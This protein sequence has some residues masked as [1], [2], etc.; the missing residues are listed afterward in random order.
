VPLDDGRRLD[1]Y[2]R[3]Q[4]AGPY[5]V[6]PDPEQAVDRKQSRSTGPLATKNAQLMME[7][8]VL[9]FQN[10]PATESARNNGDDGTQVLEHTS[11]TTTVLPKTLDFPRRSEFLVGTMV[12]LFWEMLPP[13]LFFFIALMLILSVV[14][15]LALWT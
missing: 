13:V 3:V 1:Q 9:Q 6:E 15:L 5:S 8:K 4:T 2:H 11:D 12:A 10:G 14:K 7:S